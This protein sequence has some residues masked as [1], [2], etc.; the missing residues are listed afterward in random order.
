[1]LAIFLRFLLPFLLKELVASGAM[2]NL[3]ASA[4]T[5]IKDFVIWVRGLRT[6]PEYPE[7]DADKTHNFNRQTS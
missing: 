6:Y 7:R 1:M 2:S 3:E 4:I 5:D